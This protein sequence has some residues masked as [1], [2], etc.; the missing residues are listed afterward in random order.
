M[1]SVILKDLRVRGLAA[2]CALLVAGACGG[3]GEE[4]AASATV[5]PGDSAA[6]SAPAAVPG[7]AAVPNVAQQPVPGAQPNASILDS[8]MTPAEASKAAPALQGPVNVD[9]INGYALSMDRLRKLVQGG[10][11]LAALQARRP[12][13]RDSMAIP[14][15]DPN[16][17]YE[18]LNAVPE[19]R[20]AIG[21]AGLTPREYATATAALIQAAMVHEMRKAGREPPVK[22][23]EANV[24]FVTDHWEEIQTM[25][26]AAAPGGGQPKS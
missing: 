4:K 20:A 2:A 13:L 25:M 18:R 15:M 14:T 8:A 26:R 10:Q 21:Q 22:V 24:K 11:N 6:A 9:A 5:A 3:D 16:A 23:N 17:V 19:A 7:T 1:D 12:D